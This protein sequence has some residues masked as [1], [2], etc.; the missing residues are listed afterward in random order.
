MNFYGNNSPWASTAFNS[1]GYLDIL[2]KRVFPPEDDDL[3]YEIQSQYIYRPDLLSFDLYKNAKLWWV[4]T[5]RN[6]D[7]LKDPVFD[8]LPGTKIYLPKASRLS[9]YLGI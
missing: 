2:N 9:V 6:P 3:L 5:I 4:F 1:G 7:I 8:F